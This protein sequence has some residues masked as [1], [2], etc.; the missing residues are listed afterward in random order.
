MKTFS[1]ESLVINLSKQVEFSTGKSDPS[2]HSL[3]D[4]A[5]KKTSPKACTP[6]ICGCNSPML[7]GKR[8]PN[9]RFSSPKENFLVLLQW[10]FE[11]FKTSKFSLQVIPDSN[12]DIYDLFH[13]I[14]KVRKHFGRISWRAVGKVLSP[15]NSCRE[16]RH[17]LKAFYKKYLS[18]F[19]EWIYEKGPVTVGCID[20]EIIVTILKDFI[21]KH[22][23]D[24]QE[25]A[26]NEIESAITSDTNHE[27]SSE[28]ISQEVV[29]TVEDLIKGAA[30]IIEQEGA[31]K[32]MKQN[33]FIKDNKQDESKIEEK[34]Q[35]RISEDEC[36]EEV[37]H[38]KRKIVNY[39]DLPDINAANEFPIFI[40][41]K[42]EV[43][44]EKRKLKKSKPKRENNQ[45]KVEEEKTKHEAKEK[46]NQKESV[47]KEESPK[48]EILKKPKKSEEINISNP[49][50][51]EFR[52][53]NPTDLGYRT[54]FIS[55]YL[56]IEMQESHKLQE[57][58]LNQDNPQKPE[59]ESKAHFIRKKQSAANIKRSCGV[60]YVLPT[61]STQTGVSD[62]FAPLPP[63]AFQVGTV[64]RIIPS[65][66]REKYFTMSRELIKH[67]F[68][69]Q[70]VVRVTIQK[71]YGET[72]LKKYVLGEMDDGD[73]VL[74]EDMKIM[75]RI[76][77]KD[78]FVVIHLQMDEKTLLAP[79]LP[80]NRG[81]VMIGFLVKKGLCGMKS[82]KK[83]LGL[84]ELETDPLNTYATQIRLELYLQKKSW[85]IAIPHARKLLCS[86]IYEFEAYIQRF[87]LDWNAEREKFFVT[88]VL[89]PKQ[90]IFLWKK[91]CSCPLSPLHTSPTSSW[92]PSSS[93]ILPNSRSCPICS[94]FTTEPLYTY[95][96]GLSSLLDSKNPP[97][98]FY[99]INTRDSFSYDLHVKK[100]TIRWNDRNIIKQEY[101][102]RKND[103]PSNYHDWEKW[104]EGDYVRAG[105]VT[106]QGIFSQDELLK[107]EEK[108]RGTEQD[109]RNGQFL[110]NTAQPSYG[111][112]GV[113]KRT[114][115]FFGTR[116]MWTATQLAEKQSRVAA[117]VR[118]DVSDTPYWM[119]KEILDPLVDSGII[120]KNFIN[121]IAM[122][123]YHDGKEGLAQ[124]FDDAVRFK[125][126]IY[127]VKLGSD[128]RLSFGS[129]FYG[130][131]NGAF[132]IPCPRGVVCVMEEFS[133][134][135][136]SAKHCVRPCDMSGRSITLILRQI[137]PFI[138][139]E[140]RKYDAE[141]DLPTWFSTLS[142][143]DDSVP[144]YK[145]KEMEAKLLMKEEKEAGKKL[146]SNSY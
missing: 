87:L 60:T 78:N 29:D 63:L 34:P 105:I 96:N 103:L 52:S 10:F 117:G 100:S 83:C 68:E 91:S 135:A 7:M 53:K 15:I 86:F 82:V 13:C 5:S 75:W 113:I 37:L 97:N 33:I 28:I 11:E 1:K 17:A 98:W 137:H 111:A 84:D 80:G 47:P 138:M 36:E 72:D 39:E 145:Q 79:T 94:S 120:E 81:D 2:S 126:P 144:Y 129:Q 110:I 140:A 54:N 130:Y 95:E 62:Q 127:T 42:I 20:T 133:Y 122:N 112:G 115:F 23:I 65:E 24:K 69:N 131:L 4:Q 12:Y 8:N 118:V 57:D 77:G 35:I 3:N 141:I 102:F 106:Y 71:N 134:A 143:D 59:K 48:N 14:L 73:E 26:S 43:K 40:V 16:S 124:H 121:S 44:E 125:Q 123:I 146:S 18:D 116:Y 101:Y 128:A 104:L 67:L 139:E 85:K 66:E 76:L 61:E 25:L 9:L 30:K 109:F 90:G 41:Q 74:V 64:D 99:L 46:I 51:P 32:A 21:P 142:L 49:M 93:W 6:C 55:R 19:E 132:C 22:H 107:L 89:E 88:K 70:G 50:T 27:E 119:K 56:P 45:E 58:L 38:K 31:E 114:K 92:S 136:N 108:A